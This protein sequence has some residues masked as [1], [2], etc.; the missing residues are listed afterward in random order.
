M[1]AAGRQNVVGLPSIA[2]GAGLFGSCSDEALAETIRSLVPASGVGV[3]VGVDPK[4]GVDVGV[5]V[6]DPNAG[7]SG[8]NS[9]TSRHSTFTFDRIVRI[10]ICLTVRTAAKRAERVTLSLAS[11]SA[12]VYSSWTVSES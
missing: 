3:P 11:T 2:A 12:K 10:R 9:R 1:L 8:W 4:V 7:G 6:H 5:A